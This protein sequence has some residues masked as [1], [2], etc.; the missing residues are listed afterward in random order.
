MTVFVEGK[1]C[2]VGGPS[3]LGETEAGNKI[4]AAWTKNGDPLQEPPPWLID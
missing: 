4:G 1:A 2:R 3:F